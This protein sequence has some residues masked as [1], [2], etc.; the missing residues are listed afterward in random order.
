MAIEIKQDPISPGFVPQFRK[1]LLGASTVNAVSWCE[2][3]EGHLTVSEAKVETTLKGL[4]ENEA[5]L[6]S[7]VKNLVKKT[8]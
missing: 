2:Y 6:R 4:T 5:D 3:K 8:G 7:K 1:M